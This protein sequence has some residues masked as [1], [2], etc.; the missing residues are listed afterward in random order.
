VVDET[1]CRREPELLVDRERKL[2]QHPNAEA[3]T[4]AEVAQGS[5]EAAFDPNRHP[6]GVSSADAIAG[7]AINAEMMAARAH[8][9]VRLLLVFSIVESTRHGRLIRHTEETA[10]AK[11]GK[12]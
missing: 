2:A 3:G 7:V 12:K 1:G 9:F 11:S 5:G 4:I 6:L 10:L 8:S